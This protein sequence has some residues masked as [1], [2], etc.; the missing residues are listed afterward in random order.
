MDCG[1]QIPFCLRLLDMLSGQPCRELEIQSRAPAKSGL[2][3]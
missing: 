2:E 1:S 3:A